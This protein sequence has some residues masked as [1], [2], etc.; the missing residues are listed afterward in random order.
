MSYLSRKVRHASSST[1][2][3]AGYSPLYDSLVHGLNAERHTV[4][5]PLIFGILFSGFYSTTKGGYD[6]D[7]GWLDF[8]SVFAGS[9]LSYEAFTYAA[10]HYLPK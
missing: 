10:Q 4:Y 9:V 8:V 6:K 1:F 5:A 2:W 3:G 7:F